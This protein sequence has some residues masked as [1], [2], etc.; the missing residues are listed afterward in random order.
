MKYLRQ[1]ISTVVLWITS[2]VPLVLADEW[3]F[4]QPLCGS[5]AIGLAGA[6]TA[7][8]N[9][10][11]ALCYNPAGLGFVTA[12]K[13]SSS[14]T[15]Y[16]FG[17]ET[18]IDA[19]S[20]GNVDFS[21][22]GLKGFIGGLTTEPVLLPKIPVAIVIDIPRAE[23]T[24]GTV[25]FSAAPELNLKDGTMVYTTNNLDRVIL[26]GSALRPASNVAIGIALGAQ[27]SSVRGTQYTEG[28]LT[29]GQPSLVT[30][31]DET[32]ADLWF[33][34]YKLGVMYRVDDKLSLG[35]S[36][37]YGNPIKEK[38]VFELYVTETEL[39]ST[40]SNK[41]TYGAKSVKQTHLLF[42]NGQGYKRLPMKTRIGMAYEFAANWRISADIQ[43]AIP[44]QTEFESKEG[45]E[46]K[47]DASLG[48]M[49][50]EMHPV[51]FYAGLFTLRDTRRVVGD[52]AT[53][54]SGKHIDAY[55]LTLLASLIDESSEYAVGGYVTRGAGRGRVLNANNQ[56]SVRDV[57]TVNYQLTA[58]L[59]TA[60]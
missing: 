23:D 53:R 58:S 19:V 52:D 4:N 35:V 3:H 34:L 30:E 45:V 8:S 7:V 14:V 25:K 18:N 2:G 42:E 59:T 13:M 26:L 56:I 32:T 44:P 60:L 36:W 15:S 48:L 40:A 28:M 20:D 51:V 11:S 41:S 33:A 21:Y 24:H 12:K 16:Q 50:T 46:P 9:D 39:T 5:Q 54:A 10:T 47:I 27:N 38:Q 37:A 31:T 57:K 29:Q 55:G 22:V 1:T 43:H 17:K 49:A 6:F